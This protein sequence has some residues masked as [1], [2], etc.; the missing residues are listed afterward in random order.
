MDTQH[1]ARQV[2]QTSLRIG[3]DDQVL[4]STW[5][6]T[7]PLAEALALECLRADAVPVIELTTD[8]LYS[9]AV[10][11]IGEHTLRK[12]SQYALAAYEALTAL[13]TLAGPENPRIFELGA[14][15]KGAAMQEAFQPLVARAVERK[16]RSAHLQA[17]HVTPQR[18]HKYGVDY[19]EWRE[20]HDAALSADLTRMAE[21]GRRVAEKLSGARTIRLTHP[22]GT[23]LTVACEGRTARVDDGVVDDDDRASGNVWTSLPAGAVSVAPRETSAHGRI[24]FPAV[25]L[26]G[27]VIKEL[28]FE[29]E[30]GKLIDVHAYEHGTV[31]LDFLGGATE[32]SARRIG[33]LGLGLNPKARPVLP[34]LGD[35]IV[36]GAVTLGIG[37]NRDLGGENAAGF[38]WGFALHGATV[39]VDGKKVV[40][41]G[42]LMVML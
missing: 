39:E 11:E 31:F 26:W 13:I 14:A 37:E 38:G 27:K 22:N 6:H 15:S 29:F 42:R 19:E 23:D 34:G 40:V 24:V 18:A 5:Q 3:P 10:K 25:P 2:V 41:E 1:L 33:W 20:A 12:T 16:V 9:A 7:L 30:A 35:H 21:E 4:I 36:R 8:N 17:G 28:A 32:A